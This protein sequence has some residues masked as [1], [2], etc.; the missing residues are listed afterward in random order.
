MTLFY[1]G[2]KKNKHVTCQV[3]IDL[4]RP[5]SQRTQRLQELLQCPVCLTPYIEPRLLPCGH[6][7]CD[8]CL[9]RLIQNDND[10]VT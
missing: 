9:N 6:T 7:Y 8:E 4:F 5:L 2:K 3:Q 10:V 1:F